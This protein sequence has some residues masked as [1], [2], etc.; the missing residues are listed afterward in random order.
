MAKDLDTV[1]ERRHKEASKFLKK[2]IA[3]KGKLIGNLYFAGDGGKN[4]G[5]VLTLAAK[6]P[7]GQKA[8]SG[9]KEIRKLIKNAKFAR[10]TIIMNGSKLLVEVVA[11]TAPPTFLKKAFKTETFSKDPVLKLLARSVIRKQT[12]DKDA[13]PETT[14]GEAIT[15]KEIDAI[16]EDAFGRGGFLWTK[17]EL[18]ILMESQGSATQATITLSLE[19]LSIES[20]QQETNEQVAESMQEVNRLNGEINRL[21]EMNQTAPSQSNTLQMKGYD[22]LVLAEQAR[23]AELQSNGAMPY[24]SGQVD[25]ATAALLQRA[26]NVELNREELRKA[27]GD[28]RKAMLSGLLQNLSAPLA[29]F[30]IGQNQ[31]TPSMQDT[32]TRIWL[33][34]V[35]ESYNSKIVPLVQENQ[36]FDS[37]IAAGKRQEA[38]VL[39]HKIKSKTV[40]LLSSA[41]QELTR[42]NAALG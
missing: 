34:Q 18:T 2:V 30:G 32:D 1:L 15:A 41:N 4:A 24:G 22:S 39:G 7:K 23:L 21:S 9:G 10:A 27:E 29:M 8:L 16:S 31:N 35:Q 5:I 12:N 37:L 33:K 3:S 38:Q 6:D 40:E 13:K 42:V 28:R 20:I 14:E 36:A 17:S 11:G 25:P 19:F 26:Q